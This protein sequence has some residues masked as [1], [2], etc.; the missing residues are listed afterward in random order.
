MGSG[1]DFEY[2]TC[3]NE[4]T[5]VRCRGC[6]H[7]HLREVPEPS[8]LGRIYPAHYGNYEAER[9]EALT[10][11][12]KAWLDRRWL[13]ALGRLAPPPRAVLDVGCADGRML[14]LCRAVHPGLERLEGV[15]ISEQ[16]ARA[17]R[18]RGHRVRV[19]SIEDLE[20]PEAAYDLILLQQVIE[21]LYAPDRA[22]AKLARALRPGGLVVL[23]TPTT[24]CLDF[25]WF[26]R[27]HWGGYHFPRHFH[28]FSEASLRALCE[29]AGLE[30]VQTS[31]RPQPIH[32]VW[33]A[34]HL[35][36]ERG[37][38]AAVVE[39]F[40]IG[41]VPLMGAATLVE[42]A[43]GLATGRMSNLRLVARR[44]DAGAQ[45]GASDAPSVSTRNTPPR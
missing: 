7:H 27:R 24:D 13:R 23:E 32:W 15:E 45:G 35:L 26:H 9:S 20:L 1:V 43:A 10:F 14:E 16:A 4:F 33:T 42:L 38:P 28:L 8:E 21:H 30:W 41:N 40:H 12:V 37:W 22:C 39:R 29:R 6:G 3:A 19:G 5:F 25:R 44:P 36:Q 34:H 17:A 11:R 2:A 31:H 18:A